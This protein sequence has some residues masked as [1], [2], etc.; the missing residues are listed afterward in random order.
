MATMTVDLT[1]MN[2]AQLLEYIAKVE[3]EK[4]EIERKAAEQATFGIKVGRSGTVSVTGFGRYGVSLYVS[5]WLA[6]IP[7][8]PAIG[9][10]IKAYAAVIEARVAS[11]LP[12]N[13]PNDFKPLKLKADSNFTAPTPSA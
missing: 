3:A 13:S 6:L 12:E 5:Q 9:R 4:A 11:P 2:T 8:I 1:K 7:L 10:F